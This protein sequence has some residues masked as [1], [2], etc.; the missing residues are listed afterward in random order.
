MRIILILAILT[1]VTHSQVDSFKIKTEMLQS[2]ISYP[3]PSSDS[4]KIL[5]KQH[6]ALNIAGQA[7]L[8]PVMGC[9]CGFIPLCATFAAAWSGEDVYSWFGVT[10]VS[11]VLGVSLGVKWIGRIENKNLSY[12]Q[13]VYYSALG[14]VAGG[15]ATFGIA[16]TVNRKAGGATAIAF[17][18]SSVIGAIVYSTSI[19]E[20]NPKAGEISSPDKISSQKEI[21]ERTKLFD[22]DLLKVFF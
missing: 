7:V 21:I 19:A 13:T 9:V 17:L 1:S 22:I 10:A 12:W 20:W 11:Y 14:G 18:T 3:L 5:R 16:R 8:A 15:A 6:S 4:S 2:K